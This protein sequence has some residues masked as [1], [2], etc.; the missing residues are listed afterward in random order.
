MGFPKPCKRC[1]EIPEIVFMSCGQ[2]RLKCR[3]C[4]KKTKIY[5]AFMPDNINAAIEAAVAE[6]NE[7]NTEKEE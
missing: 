1:G 7:M 5:E 2:Y 4:K 3:S 6:W